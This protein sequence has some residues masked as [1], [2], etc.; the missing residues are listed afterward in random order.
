MSALFPSLTNK[1]V[2]MFLVSATFATFEPPVEPFTPSYHINAG[3]FD[4]NGVPTGLQYANLDYLLDISLN[5]PSFQ[6][7]GEV[8]ECE[9]MLS[10][11]VDLP[12]D[13]YFHKIKIPVFYVGAAGGE[14]KYGQDV[15][16]LLGSSDQE[17]LIVELYPPEYAMLD[18]GHAD[19]LW[20]DNAQALVWEPILNWLTAH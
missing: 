1:E 4:A 19:L 17:A 2:A 20:A 16:A 6:S 9:A 13:D 11:A 3:I 10:E 18:Y 12:Y 8:L 5:T 15:L 14:G 7:I